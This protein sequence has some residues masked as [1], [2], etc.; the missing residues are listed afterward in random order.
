MIHVAALLFNSLINGPYQ[1]PPSPRSLSLFFQWWLID[2]SFP[3]WNSF[4]PNVSSNTA[5]WSLLSVDL[6][7]WP[8]EWPTFCFIGILSSEMT[9]LLVIKTTQFIV[10]GDKF[11]FSG[12]TPAVSN[13]S[14]TMRIMTIIIDLKTAKLFI[15]SP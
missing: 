15:Q 3:G 4:Q 6:V 1:F 10:I 2:S 9:L 13:K 11:A 5:K 8:Q 7:I 12:R 14:K